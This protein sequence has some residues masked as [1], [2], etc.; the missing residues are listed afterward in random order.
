MDLVKLV[1]I[2]LVIAVA[3]V[4][5]FGAV[6]KLSS[7]VEF[8]KPAIDAM[9]QPSAAPNGAD[10]GWTPATVV[11]RLAFS[12]VAPYGVT[13]AVVGVVLSSVVAIIAAIYLLRF[14]M[15]IGG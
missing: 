1:L 3:A 4:V 9:S 8:G 2:V 14:V 11:T 7:G 12:L 15:R 5:L 6:S 13:W 10:A